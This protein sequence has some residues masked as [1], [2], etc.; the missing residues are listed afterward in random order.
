MTAAR[1]LAW[2]TAPPQGVLAGSGRSREWPSPVG[3]G[4]FARGIAGTRLLARETA[5]PHGVAGGSG[6]SERGPWPMGAPH[7]PPFN[8][9]PIRLAF[10]ITALREGAPSA[11]A[12]Q[13]ALLPSSANFLS[14]SI[15]CSVHITGPQLSFSRPFN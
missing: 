9:I 1:L 14:V 10:P 8:L 13:A 3:A 6:H 4:F 11:A 15:A 12:I 7:V 5:L 2:E